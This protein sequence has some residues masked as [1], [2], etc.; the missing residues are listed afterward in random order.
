MH[1]DS[2]QQWL[3]M[4]ADGW[5]DGRRGHCGSS[6]LPA[7]IPLSPPPLR[8]RGCGVAQKTGHAHGRAPSRSISNARRPVVGAEEPPHRGAPPT[9][10]RGGGRGGARKAPLSTVSTQS[11]GSWKL[12]PCPGGEQPAFV[13]LLLRRADDAHRGVDRPAEGRGHD[14]LRPEPD[15]AG[16]VMTPAMHEGASQT[17]TST[18]RPVGASSGNSQDN[19]DG[20][21]WK[22][23]IPISIPIHHVHSNPIANGSA[24]TCRAPLRPDVALH[25]SERARRPASPLFDSPP[26][27]PFVLATTLLSCGVEVH[28]IP[29]FTS[30]FVQ[31]KTWN[32]AQLR[33]LLRTVP[34]IAN[35][36]GRPTAD[37]VSRPVAV[38]GACAGTGA[39]ELSR[40]GAGRN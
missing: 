16:A 7:H 34:G 3:H 21:F 27:S 17:P 1:P 9:G 26:P 25:A 14:E 22:W 18:A 13:A 15:R 10:A 8:R 23:D 24:I 2:S 32:S 11:T 31:T 29:L 36:S 40:G 38:A 39:G 6:R 20:L 12:N 37:A 19:S 28:S 4:T 5:M 35:G 30:H 33:N